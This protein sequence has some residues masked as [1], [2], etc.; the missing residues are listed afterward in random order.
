M[1]T[2]NYQDLTIVWTIANSALVS[3]YF[4]GYEIQYRR[5]PSRHQQTSC[6]NSQPVTVTIPDNSATQYTLY[7]AIPGSTYQFSVTLSKKLNH[8]FLPGIS[9]LSTTVQITA[10]GSLIE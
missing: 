10:Q 3:R 6:D 5:C 4:D 8:Y 9:G 7:N 2:N 1:Q